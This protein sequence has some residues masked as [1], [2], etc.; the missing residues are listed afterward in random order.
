MFS[1]EDW[2][3]VV[4]MAVGYLSSKWPLLPNALKDHGLS[5]SA[6]NLLV[7]DFTSAAAMVH[8]LVS[9]LR[10]QPA[11]DES[12][13]D[14][15]LA[16]DQALARMS[17]S[18]LLADF[19]AHVAH[20]VQMWRGKRGMLFSIDPESTR[21]TTSQPN[22]TYTPTLSSRLSY[23]RFLATKDGLPPVKVEVLAADIA[24]HF[25]R[26]F[27]DGTLSKPLRVGLFSLR[28]QFMPSI[29]YTHSVQDWHGF[30]V[31]DIKAGG[32]EAAVRDV[33]R[34]AS[35]P[36]RGAHILILPE[37]M[38][39]AAGRDIVKNA[40]VE[41]ASDR[42]LRPPLLT[43][44]GSCHMAFGKDFGNSCQVYS[45]DDDP[46][47]EPLWEQWKR[48][49][50]GT[51]WLTSTARERIEGFPP[52]EDEQV[53]LREDIEANGPTK[54]IRTPVGTIAIAICSDLMPENP[55][56][57]G[58]YLAG[59]P[60][61]C[62]VVPAFSDRTEPFKQRAYWLTRNLTATFFV[63]AWPAVE[64]AERRKKPPQPNDEQ[65]PPA[66]GQPDP[67]ERVLASFVT[68]PWSGYPIEFWKDPQGRYVST[69]QAFWLAI[70]VGDIADGLI[71]E[72][73]RLLGSLDA[74][75]TN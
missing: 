64:M 45:F 46:R 13:L 42:R 48:E 62:L 29:H 59:V 27:D 70:H 30:R 4:G 75:L 43:I 9:W 24:I 7:E 18:D 44:A 74:D 49:R 52:V 57:P 47:R 65:L 51:Q 35:D 40:L 28:G 31:G 17:D 73:S 8:A 25:L 72:V 36:E 68:T 12:I 69:H 19:D 10:A 26:L 3:D 11:S 33:V 58:S 55:G 71:V 50:Y 14:F 38:I 53:N 39:T 1:E 16:F 21:K 22:E 54:I 34:A 32:Y 5:E 67:N 66:Q 61:D 63:N 15:V 41:A 60:V 2:R 6:A 20:G 56:A 37:F 23:L